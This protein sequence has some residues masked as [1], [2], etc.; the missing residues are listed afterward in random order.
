[1]VT[2]PGSLPPDEPGAAGAL[3]RYAL[4]QRA[5]G[6]IAPLV[7]AVLAFLIGGLVVLTT[8]KS[9]G[10]TLAT[11]QAIFEGAGLNWFLPWETCQDP[12]AAAIRL[13]QTLLVWVPLVLT[14]IAVGFAFRCGL[15]NIGGQGQYLAG[16]LASVVIAAEL[17][18]QVDLSPVPLILL[19]VVVAMAAGGLLAGIAGLLKATVGAHEVITTIMLNWIVIWVGTYLFGFDGLLQN[20]QAKEIP[21]S[22]FVDDDAKLTQAGVWGHPEL[23]GL[24]WISLGVAFVSLVVYSL[25]LNRTTLGYEVRAVGHNPEGARYGGISV[26]RNYVLAMAIAGAF[27]GLAGALDVLGWKF[28]LDTTDFTSTIGFIGIA[29]A[30]LGRNKAVGIGLAALLFAALQ[31]GTS[32]RNLDPEIF[33]PELATPLTIIIQGLI[34]LFIGADIVILV[35]LQKL[36]NRGLQGAT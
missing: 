14:G 34:V 29:V 21:A 4:L 30:L 26:A 10:D 27:A 31:T 6:L 13:E 16:A 3:E 32:T 20:D 33:P 23:Q 28:R 7:T 8:T 11:Y 36:R 17:P 5:G 9:L 2:Q 24:P 35:L 12:C 1:T 19:T 18:L 15:F 22:N 25:V